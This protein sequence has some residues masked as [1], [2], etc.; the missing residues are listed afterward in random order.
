[1]KKLSV[2]FSSVIIH[3]Y[4]L[5]NCFHLVMHLLERTLI[6]ENTNQEITVFRK[7]KFRDA[8][9]RYG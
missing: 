4:R 2:V 5:S 6:Q 1:M 9:H 7:N 3:S 8:I